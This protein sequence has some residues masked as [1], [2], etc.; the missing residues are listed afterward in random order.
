MIGSK[1]I[2]KD[3]SGREN[4]W[5]RSILQEAVSGDFRN[6]WTRTRADTV[7][8][9]GLSFP[10]KTGGGKKGRRAAEADR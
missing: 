10:W 8:S 1:D 3:K 9:Q 2:I 7:T 4:T 6:T 5:V